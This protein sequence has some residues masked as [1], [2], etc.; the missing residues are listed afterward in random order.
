MVNHKSLI[1]ITLVWIFT[2]IG[3]IAEIIPILQVLSLLLAIV[4]SCITIYKYFKR[5]K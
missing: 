3:Y 1:D 4:V 5:I 2:F